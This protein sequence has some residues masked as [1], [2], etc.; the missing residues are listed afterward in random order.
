MEFEPSPLARDVVQEAIGEERVSG[1]ALKGGGF[2]RA[3]SAGRGGL[4]LPGAGV[5]AAQVSPV[6]AAR[7]RA[8][9]SWPRGVSD[10]FLWHC[11]FAPGS[12]PVGESVS[13]VL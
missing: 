13:H 1:L 7:L 11:E 12:F 8:R 2:E 3:A 5:G 9:E 6:C 10:R 4:S